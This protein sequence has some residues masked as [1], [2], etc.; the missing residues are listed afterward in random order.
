MI[1]FSNG[2]VPQFFRLE[3]IRLKK[4]NTGISS[5]RKLRDGRCDGSAWC[6]QLRVHL[7][8]FANGQPAAYTLRPGSEG[9]RRRPRRYVA[10]RHMSTALKVSVLESLFLKGKMDNNNNQHVCWE[11]KFP[12][13]YIRIA[14]ARTSILPFGDIVSTANR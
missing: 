9:E 6:A 11:K 2:M 3:S 5:L 14:R 8:L 7:Q 13:I 12:Y 1:V 10:E 4:K